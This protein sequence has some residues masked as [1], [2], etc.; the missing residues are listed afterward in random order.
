MPL[1]IIFAPNIVHKWFGVFP[2]SLVRFSIALIF[3]SDTYE[4]M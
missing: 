4:K 2:E 3:L 1:L